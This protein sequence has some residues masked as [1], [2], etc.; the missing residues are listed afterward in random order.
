MP[1]HRGIVSLQKGWHICDP[2]AIRCMWQIKEKY[3]I[4]DPKVSRTPLPCPLM[5]DKV[6]QVKEG[7]ASGKGMSWETYKMDA[8]EKDSEA[9]YSHD[10]QKYASWWG[11]GYLQGQQ[12]LWSYQLRIDK[13]RTFA[14]MDLQGTSKRKFVSKVG[15]DIPHQNLHVIMVTHSSTI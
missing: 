13:A 1:Q 14:M 6:L 11:F 3:N 10:P 9:N 5:H 2:L 4:K 15:D 7:I 12:P 8:E